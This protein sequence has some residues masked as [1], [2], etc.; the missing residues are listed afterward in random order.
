M[1]PYAKTDAKEYFRAKL[2]G[3][4]METV[5][6]PSYKPET[7]E[8][9]EE[10][11]RNDI[12]HVARL[13]G[14]R[15][16][17]MVA[18]PHDLEEM[19]RL[20]EISADEAKKVGLSAGI[21]I[22]EPEG[23]PQLEIG[24]R[25]DSKMKNTVR[26]IKEWEEMGGEIFFFGYPLN[27]RPKSETEVV[28]FT[29]RIANQVDMAFI[30]YV[31]RHHKWDLPGGTVSP[32]TVAEMA[33]ISNAV[34]IKH[35]P[36]DL[37]HTLQT[38]KLCGKQILVSDPFEAHWI[39]AMESGMECILGNCIVHLWQ[40]EKVHPLFDYV[41]AAMR[42]DF[43]QAWEIYWRLQ[44]MRDLWWSVHAEPF[45]M[46]LHPFSHWKYWEGLVGMTGGPLRQVAPLV[47]H[48]VREQSKALWQHYGILSGDIAYQDAVIR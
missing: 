31:T 30:L 25:L 22:N 6:L 1:L 14:I 40:T 34:A 9:D 19:R 5:L 11:I 41:Q 4:G 7:L 10:G 24:T 23:G 39:P 2:G 48:E 15:S 42:G 46:G 44:P 20:M 32:K 33:G 29:R 17:V 26:I 37:A 43:Q 18:A 35:S 45:H 21:F 38:L 47:H 12:R 27:F 13:P 16:F 3:G 36:G 8:L 28:E